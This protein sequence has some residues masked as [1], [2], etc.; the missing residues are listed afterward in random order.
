MPTTATL[1]PWLKRIAIALLLTVLGII[2][3]ALLNQNNQQ[4]SSSGQTNA[5]QAARA[6]TAFQL[7]YAGQPQLSNDDLRG[8]WTFLFFGY[9]HCPDVCP[10]TLAELARAHA[11]LAAD[12]AAL[13]NVQFIFVSVDPAR[14]SPDSLA[15]YSAYFNPTFIGVTG[16]PEQ[17]TAL[18]AQLD[19]TF[20]LANTDGQH[21]D[22]NV[23]H[24]SAI[25]LIDPQVRYHARLRAPHHAE[26][27]RQQFLTIRQRYDGRPQ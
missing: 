18:A 5:L 17:L 27:I 20:R 14:D 21:E 4:A 25:L 7:S 10:S 23:D 11:L 15:Q 9:S 13:D 12:P 2:A 3:G 19:A 22:Y 1:N 8:K 26:N 16:T 24:T 6:L